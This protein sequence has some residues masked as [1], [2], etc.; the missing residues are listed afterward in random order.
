MGRSRAVL[1]HDDD[2]QPKPQKYIGVDKPKV[3]YPQEPEDWPG[4]LYPAWK[5]EIED[6]DHLRIDEQGYE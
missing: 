6:G 1:K 4:K 2:K 5:L 3:E